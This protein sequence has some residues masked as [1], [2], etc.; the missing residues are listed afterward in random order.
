MSFDVRVRHEADRT[1]VV[2]QGEARLGRLL[3]LVQVLDVDSATWPPG[4]VVLDLR[5]LQGVLPPVE[6]EWLASEAAQRLRRPV[7]VLA[8]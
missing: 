5:Q 7:T 8:E 2:V 3:S 1:S 4:E 6:R